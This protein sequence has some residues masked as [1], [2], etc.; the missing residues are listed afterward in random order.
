[1]VD[2][3][4]AA[5]RFDIVHRKL[6]GTEAV[7]VHLELRET[8]NILGYTIRELTRLTDVHV[9]IVDGKFAGATWSFPLAFGWTEL[10]IIVVVREFQGMGIGKAL[11]E[12]GWSRA[13]G[14][15][16]HIYMLSRNLKVVDWMR[17]KGMTIDRRFHAAP[18]AVHLH[19]FVYMASLYRH[20]EA[21][22]KFRSM[23]KCPPLVQ[24][25]LRRQP[26]SS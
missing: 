7:T 2:M 1:M 6:T 22:R 5:T 21:F 14:Q 3:E 4:T 11:F 26:E 10:A 17:A 20:V 19:D 13:V 24:G 25:V 8:P 15:G 12:A 23:R 18:I 9:A 16:R